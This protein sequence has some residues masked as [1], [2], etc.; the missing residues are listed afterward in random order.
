VSVH[1]VGVLELAVRG[2]VGRERPVAA[3]AERFT[4]DVL[5]RFGE[6][7]QST[8]P[9]RVVLI[10]R[11]DLDWSLAEADLRNPAAA[12]E[13]AEDLAAMILAQGE[14]P[15]AGGDPVVAFS[16]EPAWLAA[17]LR[18]RAAGG[19]ESWFHGTWRAAEGRKGG[20]SAP[21]RPTVVAAL[22]RLRL[23]GDLDR[24]LDALPFATVAMLDAALRPDGVDA[25]GSAGPGG[26][27]GPS[28][29]DGAEP[30]RKPAAPGA[31]GPAPEVG[32]MQS[33]P[34]AD[35]A[36]RE[37]VQPGAGAPRAPGSDGA[38]ASESDQRA[39]V[40]RIAQTRGP[41]SEDPVRAEGTPTMPEAM[42]WPT[43]VT[44]PGALA[45]L[46]TRFGGLFYLVA[47]ALELGLGEALWRACLPE[48]QVLAYAALALLGADAVADPA[49]P[50]F[51]GVVPGD[52]LAWPAVSPEQQGE[53]S[54]ALLAGFA[55]ALSM[56]GVLAPQVMLDLAPSPMGRLLVATGLGPFAVFAWPAPDARAAAAGV[57]AFLSAWPVAASPPQAPGALLSLDPGGR[58][59]PLSPTAN[60][61]APLL[62]SAPDAAAGALVAQACGAMAEL[63][64]LRAS[65]KPTT[66]QDLVDRYLALEGHVWLAPEAMTIQLPMASIDIALRRAALDRDPGWTPWLGRSVRFDFRAEEQGEVF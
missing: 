21:R 60:R 31:G 36:S 12:G 15:A 65:A 57:F 59:R 55:S 5:D 52:L 58:L 48:G 29:S 49:P 9:E 40:A 14:R 3:L 4:R 54:T 22:A 20:A 8:A 2:P 66:A 30:S 7:V 41:M 39:S 61:P 6:I 64:S 37:G 17:Y 35:A 1:R 27:P 33:A 24:V 26:T 25:T 42:Y 56:Q 53:V 44:Q 11:L 50:L 13:R 28:A 46:P 18:E 34:H 47:L 38:A 43:E 16:D 51:G 32:T 62:P 19:R 63:F 23:A 45:R 10:R